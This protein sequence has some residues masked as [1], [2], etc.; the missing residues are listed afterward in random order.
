M[1]IR[2][3]DPLEDFNQYDAEQQRDLDK[4]PKCDYCG[5]TITD[6]YLYEINDELICEECLNDNFRKSVDDYIE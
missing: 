1:F 4:L 2:G 3:G 5:H 6:E